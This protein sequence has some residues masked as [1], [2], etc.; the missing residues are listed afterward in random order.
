MAVA[1]KA[2]QARISRDART[3]EEQTITDSAP[4]T[5]DASD[6]SDDESLS[7]GA[8]LIEDEV[9]RM[10]TVFDTMLRQPM[11]ATC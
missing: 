8:R 6:T 5:S 2:T 7:A 1:S 11:P 4:D 10:R 3:G 9:W